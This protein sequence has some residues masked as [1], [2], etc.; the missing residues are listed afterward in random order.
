MTLAYVLEHWQLASF[1]ESSHVIYAVWATGDLEGMISLTRVHKKAPFLLDVSYQEYGH[2]MAIAPLTLP[3][4]WAPPDD[5]GLLMCSLPHDFAVRAFHCK[6]PSSGKTGKMAFSV[7]LVFR[8][9]PQGELLVLNGCSRKTLGGTGS[10][11]DHHKVPVAPLDTFMKLHAS[12]GVPVLPEYAIALCK[13]GS[14]PFPSTMD[15]NILSEACLAYDTPAESKN[16]PEE[17]ASTDPE[18]NSGTSKRHCRCKGKSK[19]RSK[20]SGATVVPPRRVPVI[21]T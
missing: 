1:H 11:M 19:N 21:K 7:P 14:W 9:A 18:T 16:P 20:S 13:P 10:G 3:D 12:N 17:P 8:K 6:T 4:P 15:I 5:A 2:H